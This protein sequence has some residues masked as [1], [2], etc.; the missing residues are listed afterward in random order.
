[1]PGK[2]ITYQQVELYMTS[3][4]EG[5]TQKVSAAQSGISERSGRQIEQGQRKDPRS[6]PRERT[7]PDPLATVWE[8]EL[9]PMLEEN[10]LLQAIT[11]LEYLQEKYPDKAG[12]AVYSDSVLRTLQRRVKHWRVTE[13]AKREVMFLQEHQPG[14]LGLSDFTRL[15]RV[16]ITILGKDFSHLLYHFR[17]AFSHWSHMKI[18]QGGE[19]YTALS[20]GLQEALW[21]LGGSPEEHRTDSLSAAFKN[22]REP[23]SSDFTKRYAQFCAHY[24]M[25]GTRNNP[26]VKHENGSVESPHGHLKRRIEQALLL[27]GSHDFPSIEVYRGFIDQVVRQHNRRNAQAIFLERKVLQPLP[28]YKA[29][30][31]TELLVKVTCTS[32]IQVRRVTYTVPSQL[33]GET[34]RIHLYDDR[35]IGFVGRYQVFQLRRIHA[36]R[37][38]RLHQV[39]YRHVIH[40]LVKKPQAF[41]RSCLRDELLPTEV[42]REIWHYADEHLEAHQACRLMVGLLHLACERQCEG[43]LGEQVMQDISQEK[44]KPLSGYQALF[45]Q[46][47][48]FHD[49]WAIQP[50]HA[51]STYDGVYGQPQGGEPH[52]TT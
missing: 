12:N 48:T 30:D 52:A 42:Y 44:L 4:K 2:W 20:E 34:L 33:Q 29:V 40:S 47:P 7:R 1:M 24:Q 3:R 9:K 17:L 8:K 46:L 5:K 6:R 32:T 50:Q 43:P 41:R 25:K 27:R 26:G 15:K 13:G 14:R 36:L 23:A 31:H 35:L 45:R 51:L 38:Q 22:L 10:P 18:V 16:K 19:S 37:G 21:R 49:R 39:D 11:L 28:H